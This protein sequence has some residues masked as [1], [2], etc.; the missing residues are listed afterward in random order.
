V[1]DGAHAVA[2]FVWPFGCVLVRFLWLSRT[3]PDVCC[4]FAAR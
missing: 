3:V 2:L 4:P 1:N